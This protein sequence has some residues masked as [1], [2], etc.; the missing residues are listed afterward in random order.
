MIVPFT[1][2]RTTRGVY[3]NQ[4]L[5]DAPE[6]GLA[7]DS[8]ALGEQVRAISRTRLVGYRGTLSPDTMDRIDAALRIALD[9]V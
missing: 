8:V 3:R 7:V 6:G 4:A 9:L 1:T 2:Y 5:V